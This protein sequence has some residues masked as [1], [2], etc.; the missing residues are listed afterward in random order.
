MPGD[1]CDLGL[2]RARKRKSGDGRAAQIVECEPDDP[3]G[4]AGPV[5]Y[6]AKALAAPRLAPPICEDDRGDLGRGVERGLE[7][8][9]DRDHYARA[10]LGLP[11]PNVLAV[12]G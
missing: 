1:R 7:W 8:R 9:A 5:P 12:I 11:Q 6:P 2:G 10:G 3:S 4:F